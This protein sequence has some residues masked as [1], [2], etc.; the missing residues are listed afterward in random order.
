M[1][2]S[3]KE[4]NRVL[5]LNHIKKLEVEGPTIFAVFGFRYDRFLTAPV[6]EP[7]GT[8]D[9]EKTALA[10]FEQLVSAINERRIQGGVVYM[11]SDRLAAV[12]AEVLSESGNKVFTKEEDGGVEHEESN[13]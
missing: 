7:I 8:Y 2:I 11:C 1:F 10:A 5:N 4:N 3:N 9:D 13:I 6:K 12:H